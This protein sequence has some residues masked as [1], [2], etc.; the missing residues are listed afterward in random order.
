VSNRLFFVMKW[1]YLRALAALAGLAS[2]GVALFASAWPGVYQAVRAAAQ[3][4]SAHL[5]GLTGLQCLRSLRNASEFR[6]DFLQVISAGKA[7]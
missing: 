2:G 6:G 5:N 7:S 3:S 1:A 4:P